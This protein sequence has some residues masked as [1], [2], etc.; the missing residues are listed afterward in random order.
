MAA[1]SPELFD[2]FLT[3]GVEPAVEPGTA[4]QRLA[5]LFRIPPARAAQLLDG[6]PQRVKAG[7]DRSTA[8]RYRDALR[9]TGARFAIR[10]AAVPAAAATAKLAPTPAPTT[11]PVAPTAADSAALTLAAAGAPLLAEAE[12]SRP[13]PPA[14]DTSALSLAPAF[15]LPAE[16]PAAPPAP[17]TS[18]LRI[19]P[20]G[21]LLAA[22]ER[23][24]EPPPRT[25]P[26]LSLA[27]PGALLETL[28]DERPPL[29]PLIDHLELA[30]AGAPLLAESER[31]PDAPPHQPGESRSWRLA[32]SFGE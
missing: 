15:S 17:D 25:A 18:H 7:V 9:A 28:T 6:K 20:P 11:G 29:A 1:D 4:A 5:D 24:P 19:N 21:E 23:R 30:P 32:P 2:I 13:T 26:A 16:P 22:E 12:R 8:L 31:T 27:E 3:G 10:A 14:I